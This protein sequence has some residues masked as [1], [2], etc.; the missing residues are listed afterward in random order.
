MSITYAPPPLGQSHVRMDQKAYKRMKAGKLP[1]EDR[2]DLHGMTLA[3][4]HPALIGFISRAYRDQ[5]R[6]VLVITGKGKDRDQGGPIPTRRG[7]LRHQVPDWLRMPPIGPMILDIVQ[8]NRKHGG[9]GAYYVYL[10][11]P[12]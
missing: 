8:A 11:R 6:L 3:R 9:E 7:V 5:M 12:R 10:R 1:V 4:A 2:I